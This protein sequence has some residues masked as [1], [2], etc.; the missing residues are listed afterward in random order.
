MA[1]HLSQSARPKMKAK[2]EKRFPSPY[3]I[4]LWSDE[5]EVVRCENSL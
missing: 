3:S 4:Q 2:Q 1:A 5:Y